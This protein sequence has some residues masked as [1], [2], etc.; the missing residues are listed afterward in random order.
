MMILAQTVLPPKSI[1]YFVI[2]SVL[3]AIIG[4]LFLAYDLLGRE[5]GPLRWFTLVLICGLVSALTLGAIGTILRRLFNNAFDLNFTLQFMVLGGLMGFFTVILVELPVAKTRPP[6]FS[7]KGSLIGLAFG[8]TFALVIIYILRGP[9]EA[10]VAL[11]VPC[12]VIV[13]I[14]QHITWEP[15]LANSNAY[16]TWKFVA[17]EH[18]S[19]SHPIPLGSWQFVE[20]EPPHPKPHVFSRQRFLLG[21]VLG[22]LCWFIISFIVSKD[23]TAALLESVPF[24]L[25][26]G[27]ISSTWRFIN[28]EPPHP[29]PPLFSRKGFWTGFVAGYVP[30]LIFQIWQ[31]NALSQPVSGPVEGFEAMISLSMTLL[32]V[33]AFALATAAAGS[34]AQYTLWRANKVPHRILGAFGL[35]LI[36]LATGLQGVQPFIDLFNNVK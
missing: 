30:W 5:N 28:W 26:F 27:V 6:V 29:K 21:L 24:A 13:S 19:S 15:S 35:V 31:S 1:D 7:R 25:I 34:I 9:W 23:V 32:L 17:W 18:P 2:A 11:G 12:A 4:T 33:V 36:L 8:L 20:W 14:W 16:G 3:L 22:F 10:A